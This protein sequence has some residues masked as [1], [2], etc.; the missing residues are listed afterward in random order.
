MWEIR[1][2]E[3]QATSNETSRCG[4]MARMALRGQSPASSPIL[5]F[6][7]LATPMRYS[8]SKDILGDCLKLLVRSETLAVARRDLPRAH[9]D[10]PPRHR[11][12]QASKSFTI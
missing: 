9:C 10:Q 3:G 5:P 1:P 4:T 2:R 6:L 7:F 12:T 11:K 8:I